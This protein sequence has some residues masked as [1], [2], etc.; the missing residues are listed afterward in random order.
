[1][2]AG[3]GFYVAGSPWAVV[4]VVS[5]IT[6]SLLVSYT[7]ARGEA[8]GVKCPGGLMLRAERMVLLTLAAFLDAPLTSRLGWQPGRVLIAGIALIGFG[9][10]G[11]AIY[12]TVYI[13]RLLAAK[14]TCGH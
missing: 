10:F 11:T 9:S 1:M 12:Q 4:S 13:A 14:R 7:L 2:Y 8:H 5:G 3:L 6:G